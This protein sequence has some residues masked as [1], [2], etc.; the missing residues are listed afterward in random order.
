MPSAGPGGGLSDPERILLWDLDG[1]LVDTREDLT[2]AINLLLGDL[3]FPQLSRETIVRHIGK[4]IRNLVDRS[5]EES[6]RPPATDAERRRAV[7]LFYR[8]YG[9]CLLDTT[10]PYPGIESTLG[11]L[12]E[13]GRRMAVVTNK[14]ESMSRTILEGLDLL[15]CFTV[16]VGDGT[17]P[18]RKPDPAPL[19]HALRLCDPAAGP[20][21]AALIGDS[22][23]DVE[24]GR[25]A[26]TPVCAVGWG[27]GNPAELRAA[28][29]AW[30]AETQAELDQLLLAG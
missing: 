9:T 14:P 11:A 26:G 12:R 20:E 15:S 24:T 10:R 29:P 25:N 4:G 7:E 16:V 13:A 1:T 6:G 19:L 5:L 2:R 8:H 23:I 18:A 17:V 27:F 22:L 28:H 21:R 3:G 30:W